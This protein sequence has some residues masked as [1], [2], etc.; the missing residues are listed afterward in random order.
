[1]KSLTPRLLVL[2]D[3][4]TVKQLRTEYKKPAVMNDEIVPIVYQTEDRM[5]VQL[6]SIEQEVYAVVEFTYE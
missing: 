3:G 1:V 4:V 2:T 6:D 5:I